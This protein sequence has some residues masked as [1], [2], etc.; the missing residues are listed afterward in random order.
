EDG[1]GNR[2]TGTGEYSVNVRINTSSGTPE[3]AEFYRYRFTYNDDGIHNDVRI[4]INDAETTLAWSDFK[5][6]WKW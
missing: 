1:S 4:N 2:W 6:A 3:G 5:F